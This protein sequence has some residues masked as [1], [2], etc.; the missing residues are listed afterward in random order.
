MLGED[1]QRAHKEGAA[2]LVLSLLACTVLSAKRP[3]AASC[4]LNL[5]VCWQCWGGCGTAGAGRGSQT[6]P[7]Q[8]TSHLP[9]VLPEGT[10]PSGAA[11]PES[12]GDVAV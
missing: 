11:E 9:T 10:Q 1:L 3:S 2:T 5:L 6:S 12:Q 4:C 8:E 7:G